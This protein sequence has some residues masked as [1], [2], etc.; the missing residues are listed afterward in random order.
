MRD[1]YL[2]SNVFNTLALLIYNNLFKYVFFIKLLLQSG[3][4]HQFRL[5]E[6]AI[7]SLMIFAT[8]LYIVV[9]I[10]KKAG[11]TEDTLAKLITAVS[12]YNLL[13]AIIIYSAA[14]HYEGK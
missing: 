7:L 8:L 5:L 10:R 9:N 11:N 3:L 4:Y 2:V 12:I 14:I 1:W 13:S 6:I